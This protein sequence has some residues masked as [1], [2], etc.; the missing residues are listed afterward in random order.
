[1]PAADP[2]LDE[3][4]ALLEAADS[5]LDVG[6]LERTLTDGYA[7][8]LALE[9][10]RSRLRKRIGALT[11]AGGRSRELASLARELDRREAEVDALRGQLALLRRRHSSAVRAVRG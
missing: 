2:L 7:R 5:G 4:A 8:A 6:R 1:M 3:I 10:E 11:G 9:A